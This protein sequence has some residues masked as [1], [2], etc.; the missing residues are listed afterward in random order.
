MVHCL[1]LHCKRL[2][3]STTVL[4]CGLALHG[5]LCV[6]PDHAVWSLGCVLYELATL[7]RAFDG[8]SLPALVVKILR[9]VSGNGGG[10]AAR[11]CSPRPD[12]ARPGPVRPCLT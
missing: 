12:P 4:T 9:G 5:R 7:R 2:L 1:P 11:L 3:L 8:Q 6:Y 10:S